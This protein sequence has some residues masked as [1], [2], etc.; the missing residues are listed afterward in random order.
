MRRRTTA[1]LVVCATAALGVAAAS[2][3][4]S[5][6][7]VRSAQ[8]HHVDV[9]DTVAPSAQTT[10]AQRAELRELGARMQLNPR[11]GSAFVVF[12]DGGTLTA[13]SNKKPE[14][15]A[16][17]FLRDHAALWRLSNSE[18]A[19]L[20]SDSYVTSRTGATHL[21]FEQR[22]GSRR[23]QGSSL[24]VTVDGSG[25]VVIATGTL[26]PDAH[27][28]GA[29]RVKADAA[30]RAA[31]Q[32]AGLDASAPLEPVSS[33]EG[34]VRFKNSIAK[35]LGKPR[36]ITAELVTFPVGP[37]DVRIGWEISLE[38]TPD[39]DYATVVDAQ[40][41]DLLYLDNGVA[42]ADGTV[43]TAQHPGITGATRTDQ[44]FPAGWVTGQVTRGNNV[45]AYQDLTNSNTVEYQTSTPASP[46]PNFQRFNFAFANDWAT[47][48]TVHTLVPAGATG[49]VDIDA[50]ITQMFYYTNVM[51]DFL[52]GFG[53]NAASRNF[54]VA[55]PVLAEATDGYEDGV[56]QNCVNPVRRCVNNA[57]FNT[58][59]DGTSP[60]MQM[61]MFESPPFVFRDGALDGDVIAHEFG[62]GLSGRL[63]ANANLGSSVQT[64]ALG[65][66]W[67][68]ITSASKWD[69]PVI[70]E[71]VTGNATTGFRNFSMANST[72]KL[73][74]LCQIGGACEVHNDGEIWAAAF[75][76]MRTKLVARYPATGKTFA[77]QLIVDGMKN[78]AA[79]PTFLSAR[80]GILAADVTDNS[81][82]DT[83]LIW[84]AYAG[85]EMGFSA[86]TTGNGDTNP[87]EATDGPPSC[88]P[89]AD[90][91]GPYSTP[92]GTDAAVTA[93]G[94]TENGDGPF[95]YQWDFDND[96]Q[97]DDAIGKTSSFDL[98][99]QDGVFTIGVKVTNANGF[100][101]TDTA[102]VTVTNVAP[103][104]SVG[105]DGP[106]PENTS[107]TVSG[108][109]TDP[110]WLDTLTATIDWGDGAV[111]LPGTLENLRP[112]ATLTFSASHTYGDDGIFTVTVCA[113]DDDTTGNC[114]S[115]NVTI[116]NVKPTV[117]IDLT[118]TVL[119]NGVPTFIAHE[120]VP[121]PF[122]GRS[123][124]PGSD[125][126]TL[127]WDWGDGGISPDVSTTFFNN[128][129]TNT[130]DP[131][132]SPQ[133][134]PRDV[135]DS[136]PHAFGSA[137]IYTVTFDAQDD[138][139]GN[140]DDDT[141]AV[142]IAG[143]A[144]LQRGA[145]YWQTQY[146]P[147]PTAFS[148]ERRQCYLAIARFMSSVFD[149][150]VSISTVAQAF[151]VLKISNNE[152]SA[153]QKLD[154]ELLTAW[155]NFAN[156]AF[157]LTELV[158]TDKDK[159]PDT[160]FSTV[161]ATAEAVRLNPSSTEAQLLAQRD[162]LEL[163]NGK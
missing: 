128:A 32:A 20:V 60:R 151:D 157:D 88:T 77:F 96:G 53:F 127:T 156:G 89:V 136:Q 162:I 75:W 62:H 107:V 147:R 80:D 142:I 8:G 70:G 67:S 43:Y 160:A 106:K 52:L 1:A 5:A 115:T 16:R 135:T 4:T 6:A 109:V 93:A 137:C 161:M 110:G 47:Q 117:T 46:D 19:R 44:T 76:D 113:A 45:N 132:P 146:R 10:A 66:G 69:E 65:E 130:P 7:P 51:H 144:S 26:F 111:A 33:S 41:A 37:G 73:S 133:I 86:T 92:E 64:G 22:D 9:R 59:P 141:V 84:G 85:R 17:D 83:C 97:Y 78:T 3:A 54:E 38:A 24:R 139:A 29:G 140:A 79:G 31:A 153:S 21:T 25:R 150:A 101:D 72:R 48:A 18:I 81:G 28:T 42:D 102:T 120:G 134:N 12:K 71:Y 114:N 82:N 30:V 55:D 68:D 95:T 104:V 122:A 35:G 149:E 163:I 143:N 98:V 125:D 11:L 49:Y 61:Y 2:A 99:G 138:D 152:G 14:Q 13:S 57:N 103:T 108:V 91:G 87:V 148:E 129:P 39:A 74:G 56:A 131:D 154:R 126:L 158:D 36:D 105:N 15:V 159:T 23:V 145:G 27:V 50:V 100:S 119:V 58:Q 40:T 34:K 121:V 155:L 112:D 94:S 124:D 116:T 63:I 123:T 118:G 90:A